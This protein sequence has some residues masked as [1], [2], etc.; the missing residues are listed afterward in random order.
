M[1]NHN[2]RGTLDT[3]ISE[4]KYRY[5]FSKSLDDRDVSSLC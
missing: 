4:H 3:V 5:V 1:A 2:A